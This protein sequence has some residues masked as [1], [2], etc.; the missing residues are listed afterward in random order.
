MIRIRYL[1]TL[2]YRFISMLTLSVGVLRRQAFINEG[3]EVS[4]AL[5]ILRRPRRSRRR[6][7]WAVSSLN[8]ID[9]RLCLFE[10]QYFTS[11]PV[12]MLWDPD[13][14][15]HS[16]LRKRGWQEERSTNRIKEEGQR[17]EIVGEF[18]ALF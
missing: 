1:P 10:F 15:R 3:M 13:N 4:K 5:A 8:L 17:D 18:V 9:P 2:Q 11:W 16:V 14:Y 12:K 7:S 6:G